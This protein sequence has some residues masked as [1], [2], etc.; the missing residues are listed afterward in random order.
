MTKPPK[1]AAPREAPEPSNGTSHRTKLQGTE[2]QRGDPLRGLDAASILSYIDAVARHGSIRKAAKALHIASSA[3]NR[4]VLDLEAAAG[5]PLFERLPR[6]VRATAAGE[7]FLA[8]ARRSLH[9]LHVLEAQLDGLKGLTSGHVA[10]AVAESVT[11]R[12][13]PDAIAE[14]QA[15]HPGISFSVTVDGP[16]SLSEALRSDNADLVLTHARPNAKEETV[17]ASAPQPLCAL[18]APEHPLS[19]K[20]VLR[21]RDC[22][23]YPIAMPD[24]TLAARALIDEALQLTSVNLEPSFT[25]NSI[26][27]TK[28][29]ARMRGGVC[30]SFRIGGKPDISGMV[31]IPLSDPSLADARLYLTGRRGRVLP[32]AAASF[33]EKLRAIFQTL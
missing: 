5:L 6:G 14:Y 9:D 1:K 2:V 16:A 28:V 17:L 7:L 15:E 4:R 18:V 33:A 11:G 22:V 13:L 23:P 8:Y 25:S 29:F 10:I 12:M 19:N 32:V 20:T 21:L 24:E 30:F 3:L 27:A 26:E 31:G